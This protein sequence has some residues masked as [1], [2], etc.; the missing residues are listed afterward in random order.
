VAGT[1]ILKP[2]ERR[3][4]PG[5]FGRVLRAA[6]LIFVA[7][8]YGLLCSVLP[9]QAL[10][11][12]LF[13]ILVMV[14]LILWM[15][16]DI[17]GIRSDT[18]AQ[19]MIWFAALHVA[20]PFYVAVNLPGVPWVTPTRLALGVMTLV[21][22]FNLSTSSAFR[23]TLG[24]TL[25]ASPLTRR[26]FW[27][28]T[29]C[30]IVSLPF[31]GSHV[32]FSLNKL[33]NNQVY[34]TMMFVLAAYL[35]TLPGFLTRTTR[36]I[37]CAVLFVA[38]LGLIEA[39]LKRVIWID[40]LPGFLKVD[41]GLLSTFADSQSRAYTDVYR[42]RG[43][44]GVSLYYA[45]YLS[46]TFP[47]VIH[48]MVGEKRGWATLLLAMGAIAMMLNMYLTNARSGFIG[49][50][51]TLVAYSFFF[52][53]RYYRRHRGSLLAA[54][55]FFAFPA[56]LAGLVVLVLS[57]NRLRVLTLGGGQHQASSMAREAQWHLGLPKVANLPLGHGAGRAGEV[58]G[59]TNPGGYGSIDSYF[60]SLLLDY[61]PIGFLAFVFLF[62]TTAWYGYDIYMNSENE[63]QDLAGPLAV[64]LINFVVI[65]LV[66]SSELNVPIAFLFTGAIV[67]LMWQRAHGRD[68]ARRRH[69]SGEPAPVAAPAA[70]APYRGQLALPGPA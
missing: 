68:P 29:A 15:L 35:A 36:A 64:G 57:W 4:D 56:G 22:V 59:Y 1:F 63:E 61:G 58:L 53:R 2:Y 69:W 18:M 9:P 51:L 6:G 66:L 30:S 46:M 48:Y 52:I 13:P 21:F 42:V 39:K 31:A 65:K 12:P 8:F 25:S 43:T 49:L 67:G 23:A 19:L 34:W 55:G 24:D 60:L 32:F 27:L 16:P 41:E 26:L 50:L 37:V 45:E 7:A 44:M 40:H 14:A 11:V 33:A 17:G 62:T 54:A 5:L 20:W 70:A 38:V 10:I 47:L 28:F 3:K